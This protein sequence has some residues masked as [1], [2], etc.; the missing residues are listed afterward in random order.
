MRSTQLIL[1]ALSLALIAS[2][3]CS[4]ESSTRGHTR[5]TGTNDGGTGGDG[6]TSPGDDTGTGSRPDAWREDT[7]FASCDHV[8][9][10][11]MEGNRP[12]DIV[13]VLDDSGSMDQE[14]ALVQ[15]GLNDFASRIEASGV[16]DYHVIVMTRMGWVTVPP[17]LGTDPSHF[18]F[19]DQDV[20]SHDAFDRAIERLPDFRSFLRPEAAMHFVFVTDDEAD[21]SFSTFL[22][23]MQITLGKE[24]VAHVIVSPPGSTHREVIITVPGCDGPYGQGAANGQQYWD[25]AAATGGLQLDICSADW[26]SVFDALLTVVAVPMPI[27][28]R[29]AIPDP[30]AG[31]TFDRNRVNVVY[32]PGST[33][34]DEV[35]PRATDCS[36]GSGWTY[37]DPTSPTEIVLCPD[38][39]SRVESD[40]AGHVGIQL[41]CATV[42]F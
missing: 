26:G 12:L 24:F 22:S 10:D 16:T 14:A 6:S 27:P 3:G 1:P 17:P 36:G 5:D 25:I 40:A 21:M 11:A 31:M 19:V 15:N 8:D 41:G 34:V 42:V 38:D 32:T 2:P 4:C 7:G 35:I 39:C 13:W 9:F 18:L 37:D 30:P 33:G 20:Q 28:C 23:M 29:F